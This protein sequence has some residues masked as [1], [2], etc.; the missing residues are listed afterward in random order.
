M[1]ASISLN[2]NKRSRAHQNLTVTKCIVIQINISFSC[3]YNIIGEGTFNYR[4][5]SLIIELDEQCLVQV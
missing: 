3:S 5:G 2:E 1:G 4:R